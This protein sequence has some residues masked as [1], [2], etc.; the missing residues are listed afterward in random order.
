MEVAKGC[1][2]ACPVQ[3]I[4]ALTDA[5]LIQAF[6]LDEPLRRPVERLLW[7]VCGRYSRASAHVWHPSKPFVSSVVET[8]PF[9]GRDASRLRSKRAEGLGSRF[10]GNDDGIGG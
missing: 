3:Q 5:W 9:A 10:L 6:R 1:P 7:V 2:Y 8:R 4:E